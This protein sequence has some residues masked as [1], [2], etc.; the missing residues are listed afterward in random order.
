M[1]AAGNRANRSEHA[2]WRS[3]VS[4]GRAPGRPCTLGISSSRNRADRHMSG[5][6]IVPV[7]TRRKCWGLHPD[8]W[9]RAMPEMAR[10]PRSPLVRGHRLE[11]IFRHLTMT[12]NIASQAVM[13]RLG[14]CVYRKKVVYKGLR[15]A[16]G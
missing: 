10:A 5:S 1:A 6:I 16:C 13:R 8:L 7:S 3:S 9:G 15:R 11:L 4:Q 12:D 14:P 2:R